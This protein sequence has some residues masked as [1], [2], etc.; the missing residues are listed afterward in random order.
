MSKMLQEG[1]VLGA[2]GGTIA[3]TVDNSPYH[4]Q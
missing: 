1:N 3:I 2:F 4:E